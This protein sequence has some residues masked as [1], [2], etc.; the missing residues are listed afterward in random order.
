MAT[1]NAGNLPGTPSTVPVR[2]HRQDVAI[3]KVALSTSDIEELFEIV[4]VAMEGARDRHIVKAKELQPQEAHNIDQV[5]PGWFKIIYEIWTNNDRQLTGFDKPD[6]SESHFS[7]EIKSIYLTTKGHFSSMSGGAFPRNYV[8]LSIDFRRPPLALNLINL[9]SNPTQ[10]ES[11]ANVIGLDEDWTATTYQRLNDFF[12]DK[13]VSR[14]I[15]HSSGTYDLVLWVAVVPLGLWLAY[16]IEDRFSLSSASISGILVAAIY[17]YGALAFTMLARFLFQYVRW[18]FPLVEYSRPNKNKGARL[19]KGILAIL[20]LGIVG[21]FVY[22]MV[23]LI[24]F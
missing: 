22:D 4:E 13:R 2:Q 12:S 21:S 6:F 8:E 10:N 18:L 20:G 24:F 15:I 23:K 5:M 17:V 19:Q 3:K 9:P 14:W 7:S 1:S 16:L 11:V